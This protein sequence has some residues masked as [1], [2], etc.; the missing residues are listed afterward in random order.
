[1]MKL[2]RLDKL[3]KPISGLA[4][5]RVE[6]SKEK[7]DE[8]WIPYIRPSHK[9]ESS[10]DA[11]V[12][13]EMIPSEKIF[14]KGTLY[15][16]TDGQGSHTYSYVSTTKFVANSNVCV[17]EPNRHMELGEKLFYAMCI[18]KNR[19]KFSYGRKPKGTK[20]MEILVP[21]FPPEEFSKIYKNKDIIVEKGKELIT[22]L[23]YDW[24]SEDYPT[25]D[26]LVRLDKLFIVVNGISSTGIEKS[27][28]KVNQDWVPFI[29]P[30]FKQQTSIDSYV[31]KNYIANE[32]IFPKET[33]YVS[34]NGQG[35]HTYSYVSTTEFIPNSDVSVLVPKRHMTLKE[36]L[37]YAMCITKNRYRFSYGRKPKG[38]KLKAL[39]I[40][41]FP[42]K[43]IMDLDINKIIY[44]FTNSLNKI[45]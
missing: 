2:V 5:S 20:L 7:I 11:Y 33:L 43:E 25:S 28:T 27:E 45:D 31:N 38:D 34:T 21:E 6:R 39:L 12:N 44:N 41:E 9:Q 1:M 24:S 29:R 16:S 42:N 8:N 23:N 36:K 15:V 18:T 13:K 35:S 22:K 26:K 30:S 14:P 37:F 40:P 10:I 3:F 17:L 19:Y 4:S 32:K